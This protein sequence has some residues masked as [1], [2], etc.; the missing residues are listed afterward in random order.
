MRYQ[1]YT[2]DKEGKL[3][4]A[5]VQELDKIS[6]RTIRKLERKWQIWRAAYIA[7]HEGDYPLKQEAE[8]MPAYVT[9]FPIDSPKLSREFCLEGWSH[10]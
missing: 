2:Q 6:H 4:H 7:S 3:L 1:I 9:V 5:G 10:E 8:K